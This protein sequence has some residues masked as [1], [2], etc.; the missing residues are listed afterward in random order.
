MTFSLVEQR[1]AIAMLLQAF[2]FSISPQNPSYE[3][4]HISNSALVKPEN[5]KLK[6]KL[7]E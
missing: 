5:L 3:K 6:I 2:E 7:R 1:V 4:I